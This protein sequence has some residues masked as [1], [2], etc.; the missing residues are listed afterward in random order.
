M[1]QLMAERSLS[2]TE[3]KDNYFTFWLIFGLSPNL[4][5]SGSLKDS[6]EVTWPIVALRGSFTVWKNH[7]D[8]K[9][10]IHREELKEV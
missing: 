1:S 2:P 8:A 3:K 4:E 5:L 7:V 9:H 10:K 6:Q